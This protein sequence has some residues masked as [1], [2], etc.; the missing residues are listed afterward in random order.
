MW[1]PNA[2]GDNVTELSPIGALIGNFAPAAANFDEPDGMAID[3]TGN[4]WV[5]NIAGDSVSELLVGCSTSSCTGL[6]FAS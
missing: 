2:G 3:A 6:N 4:V 5:T 1:V